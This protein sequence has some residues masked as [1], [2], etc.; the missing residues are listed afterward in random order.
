MRLHF[1]KMHG[2]GNDFV[3]ID[4]VNQSLPQ[5][6]LPFPEAVLKRL[7]DRHFGIGFDQMLVVQPDDE[8]DFRYRIFNSDGSEVAQC[9]NGAR[10]FAHFVRAKGLTDKRDIRVRT[11]AGEMLLSITDDDRVTVMMGKPRWQP[12]AIPLLADK[13]QDRYTLELDGETYEVGAVGLGNPHCVLR[14]DDVDTAPVRELG[15]KLEHHPAFPE[16]VNVGF[17]QVVDRTRARLRVF[18][19]GA[20]ETLACG[21]GAC[22]AIVCGQRLGWLDPQVDVVLRGGEVTIRHDATGDDAIYL[23]GPTAHVFDGYIDL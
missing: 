3:V 4:A 16:R 12:A 22:A 18:E 14:V 8:A 19:R 23:T 11:A 1:T 9:G 6:G 10:C 21:S 15:A 5:D 2:T 20:G 17:L 7:G 13:E